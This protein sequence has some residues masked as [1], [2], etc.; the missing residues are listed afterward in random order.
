MNYLIIGGNSDIATDVIARL[1]EDGHTIHA[2]VRSEEQAQELQSQ[3]HTTTVGDATKEADIKQCVAEAKE[4]GDIDGILHCVGSI[5]IRPPHALNQDAFEEVNLDTKMDRFTSNS[6][7]ND[8][9]EALI[10]RYPRK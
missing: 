6:V 1:N 3:G 4:K 7:R 10:V 5:V 2:L 8:V 9:W